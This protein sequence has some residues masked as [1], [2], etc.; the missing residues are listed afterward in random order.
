MILF[1][2]FYRYIHIRFLLILYINALPMKS[3]MAEGY[4]ALSTS[5]EHFHYISSTNAFAYYSRY[6]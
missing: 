6:T 5:T 1:S 3:I 4:V 2:T